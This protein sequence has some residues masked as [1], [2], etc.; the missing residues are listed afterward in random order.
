MFV[1]EEQR[2]IFYKFIYDHLDDNGIV[3]IIS[4]EDGINTYKSDINKAFNKV[5]RENI[6]TKKQKIVTNISCNIVDIDTIKEAIK[7]NID[8]FL[9]NFYFQIIKEEYKNNKEKS[10]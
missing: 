8:R 9:D 1:A 4:M 7:R 5:V 3:L 6:N 2:N 10:N